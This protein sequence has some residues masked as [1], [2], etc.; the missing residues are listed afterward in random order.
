MQDRDGRT[1]LHIAASMGHTQTLE[2][3]LRSGGDPMVR[4]LPASVPISSSND[5]VSMAAQILDVHKNT[6]V[7][8]AAIEGKCSALS[9][10]MSH[11]PALFALY[12]R[13]SDEL[14]PLHQATPRTHLLSTAMH[15]R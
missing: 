14:T 2:V 11:E 10:L 7:H 4:A 6:C 9:L 3:L 1:A 5:L 8:C 12:E 13:N 15:T